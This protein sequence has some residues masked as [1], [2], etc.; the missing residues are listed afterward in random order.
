MRMWK[1]EGTASYAGL[2]SVLLIELLVE[3][4]E[5]TNVKHLTALES[6]AAPWP[7]VQNYVCTSKCKEGEKNHS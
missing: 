2:M 7:T 1:S 4:P 5:P 6:D 3:I